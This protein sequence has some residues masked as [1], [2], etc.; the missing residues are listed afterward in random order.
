[1]ILTFVLDGENNL[2]HVKEGYGFMN[3]SVN[4]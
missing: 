2:K 1:M 3:E 4:K